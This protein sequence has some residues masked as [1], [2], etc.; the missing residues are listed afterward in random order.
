MIVSYLGLCSNPVRL[1]LQN[2]R[3]QDSQITASSYISSNLK[4]FNGRLNAVPIQG[5]SSGAW[6]SDLKDKNPW[7]QVDFLRPVTVTGILTQGRKGNDQYVTKYD[8]KYS[9]DGKTWKKHP[10]VCGYSLGNILKIC[11][12]EVY[13]PNSM[14]FTTRIH[15]FARRFS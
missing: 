4:P 12:I 5:R 2:G 14:A 13:L 3:V 8:L 6:R 1:G 9:D 15:G 11:S 10:K 7:I